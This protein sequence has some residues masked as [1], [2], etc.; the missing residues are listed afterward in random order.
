MSGDEGIV[1][2]GAQRILQGQVLYRD[3]FSFLTPGSYYFH[4]FF[5]KIF[6]SSIMA[7]RAIILVEGALLSVVTYLI[8]RYVCS[9]WSALLAS[10]CVT[11]TGLPNRL[12]V[13]HNWDSTFWAGL[14]LYCA[15]LFLVRPKR[16]VLFATGFF[17]A[18]TCLFEQS[19]GAGI[20][21]GLTAATL[22][23]MVTEKEWPVDRKSIFLGAFAAGFALPIVVTFVFFGIRHAVPQMLSAWLWPLHHYTDINKTPYGFVVLT[24]E[25]RLSLYAEPWPA[26]FLTLIASGPWAIIPGLPLIAVATL[27]WA[28]IRH[29]RSPSPKTRYFILVSA[30]LAGL[31]LSILATGRPDFMHFVFISPLSFVVIA[32]IVDGR[33]LQLSL[34]PRVLPMVTFALSASCL[35]FG[36]VLL[37][38]P[39]NAFHVVETRRGILKSVQNDDVIKYIQDHVP[40]GEPIVV[41]P[42]LPLYYYLTSTFSSGRYEYLHP[43]FHTPEQYENFVSD[44][45][46]ARPRLVL[47]EASFRQKLRAGFP[48]ATDELIAARDPVADYINAHYKRCADLNSAQAVWKFTAMIRS[49]LSC[50]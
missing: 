18:L 50:P 48:A 38:Q 5:L 42:Y 26:R 43:G 24:P 1:L 32:W 8:S 25:D 17:A 15:V 29:W 14:T 20:L 10:I 16:F 30:A 34:F 21:A 45:A 28:A 31:L 40:A 3:F 13:L 35:A 12:V 19:K 46:A 36:L 39:L 49:D 37:T 23:I 22:V 44:L 11:L 6:G 4:A 9:R 47:F 27:I 7:A 33:L 2:Q 41:Y